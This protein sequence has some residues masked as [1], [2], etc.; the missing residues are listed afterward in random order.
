VTTLS[1]ISCF[2]AVAEAPPEEP[3]VPFPACSSEQETTL[4]VLA[5]LVISGFFVLAA[6]V[7]LADFL[8]RLVMWIFSRRTP[9]KTV[10]AAQAPAQG[11]TA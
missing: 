6:M 3:N 5:I 4:S 9:P 8:V 11:I 7:G 1:T 10:E 2:F